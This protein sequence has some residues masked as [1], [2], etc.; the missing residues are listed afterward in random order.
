MTVRALDPPFVDITPHIY[1]NKG[2]AE[3][4]FARV[5]KKG[6]LPADNGE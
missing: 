1:Y 4:I 3:R 2:G 6:G 5:P